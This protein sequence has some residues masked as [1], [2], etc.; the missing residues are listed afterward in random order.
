M[1]LSPAR[2]FETPRPRR[3]PRPRGGRPRHGTVVSGTPQA[4]AGNQSGPVRAGTRFHFL[5][6]QSDFTVQAPGR[7]AT[8]RRSAGDR[9]ATSSLA[10][11]STFDASP[12]SNPGD[13]ARS[14]GLTAS[15]NVVPAR[16]LW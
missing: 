14:S 5:N 8:G 4:P 7:T 12:S 2:F 16:K 6:E 10:P 1:R 9:T 11:G 3:L 13:P 15:G